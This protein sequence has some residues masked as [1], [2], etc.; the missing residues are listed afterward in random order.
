MSVQSYY[1]Y[2]YKSTSEITALSGSNLSIGDNVF[3]TDIKKEEYWTGKGWINDDCIII[4]N[5][6][7]GTIIQGHVCEIVGT[8]GMTA[9]QDIDDGDRI[10]VTHRG[11]AVGEDVIVAQCG[12]YPVKYKAN[13]AGVTRKNYADVGVSGASAEDGACVAG[14][15]VSN[16]QGIGIQVESETF[17][18]NFLSRVVIKIKE[19]F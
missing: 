7:S 9:A 4:A 1:A 10:G 17:S 12:V 5:S 15:T 19:M 14:T 2:G 3:N 18:G 11:G 6:G 16:T 13:Q 8:T